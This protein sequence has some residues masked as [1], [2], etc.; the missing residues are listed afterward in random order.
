MLEYKIVENGYIKAL[1]SCPVSS[2]SIKITEEE[3]NRIISLIN[4]KPK[5]ESGYDYLLSESFEWDLVKLPDVPIIEPDAET[6]DYIN[7]LTTLGVD[8]N[9]EN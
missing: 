8:T 1:S 6:N 3:Y 2:D 9:E 7:A 5:A 4:T